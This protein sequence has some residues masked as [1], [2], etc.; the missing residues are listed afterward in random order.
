ML[1]RVVIVLLELM[2]EVCLFSCFVEG[3]VIYRGFVRLLF[4]VFNRGNFV[5]MGGEFG[6]LRSHIYIDGFAAVLVSCWRWECFYNGF[7]FGFDERCYS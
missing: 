4:F 6:E 7:G 1:L 3:S 5:S 2:F